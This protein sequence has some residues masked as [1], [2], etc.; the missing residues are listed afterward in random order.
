MAIGQ[1]FG[2]LFV[3][4][5][6]KGT[7]NWGNPDPYIIPGD[8]RL[9]CIKCIKSREVIRDT[10]L[11]FKDLPESVQESIINTLKGGE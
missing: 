9:Y 4:S 10:L 1:E 3:C 8:D 7:F 11:N 5:K 6:C 2:Y